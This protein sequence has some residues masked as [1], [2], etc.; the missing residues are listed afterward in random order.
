VVCAIDCGLVIHPGMVKAQM[1]G[2]IVFGLSVALKGNITFE[3]GRVHQSN[4]HDYP[5]LRMDEMPVI[6]V[7]ILPGGDSP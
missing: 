5:L 2:G 3:N 1:E 7:H 6:E 4:F